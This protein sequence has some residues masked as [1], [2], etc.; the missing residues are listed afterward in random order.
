MFREKH[1]LR[2]T[3]TW[4]A[5]FTVVFALI[6]MF[7]IY[8][9]QSVTELRPVSQA[10][11]PIMEAERLS[12]AVDPYEEVEC[13]SYSSVE[14][15]Y[16]IHNKSPNAI[17]GLK[18]PQTCSCQ[19]NGELP[20]SIAPG[21][22]ALI[23]F[24]IKAPLAGRI[25]RRIPLL[26]DQQT[27]PALVLNAL[28]R[29]RFDPPALLPKSDG[30]QLT[31][32]NGEDTRRE[33]V[34]DTIEEKKDHPWIDGLEVYPRDVIEVQPS[35]VDELPEADASLTHRRYHFPVINRTLG[36]G[37]HTATVR[38]LTNEGTPTVAVPMKLVV[39]VID[40]VT[41][42]PNPLVIRGPVVNSNFPPKFTVIR[43]TGGPLSVVLAYD[44]DLLGVKQAEPT[45]KSIATFEIMPNAKSNLPIETEVVFD[46][47]EDGT[48]AVKVQFESFPSP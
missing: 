47:G 18:L 39:E 44:H 28:L 13:D 15:A 8:Q 24:R 34:L 9:G 37:G 7:R 17:T 4:I 16:R 41:I 31:F 3:V 21:G 12:P 10:T 48:R 45:T 1:S 11:S 2:L 14:F 19:T 46:F 26:C 38:V 35:H 5:G 43:R 6:V 27:T 29:V 42:V 32:V 20:D 33:I 36:S 23:T 22:T 40:S 30:L 25:E